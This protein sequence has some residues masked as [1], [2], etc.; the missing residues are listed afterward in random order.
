MIQIT[1]VSTP[2]A[3]RTE[4]SGNLRCDNRRLNKNGFTLRIIHATMYVYQM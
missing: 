1:P 2:Q 3:A 4:T